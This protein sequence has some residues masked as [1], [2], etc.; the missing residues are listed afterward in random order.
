MLGNFEMTRLFAFLQHLKLTN[1][2][3]RIKISRTTLHI[4]ILI[5]KVFLTF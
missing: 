4:L 3:K 1:E 5:F 2:H